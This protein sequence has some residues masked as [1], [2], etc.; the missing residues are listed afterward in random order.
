VGKPIYQDLGASDCGAGVIVRVPVQSG[1][2]LIQRHGNLHPQS[3]NLRM[4][5]A[6]AIAE[7]GVNRVGGLKVSRR[8]CYRIPEAR[9]Q[10]LGRRSVLRMGEDWRDAKK[11]DKHENAKQRSP[12][13]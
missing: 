6:S 2:C 10:V 13:F 8:V 5:R 11:Y 4:Q 7:H 1:V 3:G 9:T 12:H